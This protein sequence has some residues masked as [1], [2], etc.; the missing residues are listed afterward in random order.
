MGI[1]ETVGF[2][3]IHSFYPLIRRLIIVLPSHG[4]DTAAVE[5]CHWAE[6]P[7]IYKSRGNVFVKQSKII[8]AEFLVNI[9]SLY[10]IKGGSW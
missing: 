4:Q 2:S 3:L 7:L 10:I 1:Y 5:T 9:F 6:L 8:C